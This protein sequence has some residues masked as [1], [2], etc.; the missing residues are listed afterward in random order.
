MSDKCGAVSHLVCLA[1]LFRGGGDFLLPVE[2]K[3]P[4]CDLQ[5]LWGDI[6]KKKKLKTPLLIGG[7]L[8][9]KVTT[10]DNAGDISD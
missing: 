6:V 3:C 4:V 10:H 5:C 7:D 2:G 9:E 8:E 1:G